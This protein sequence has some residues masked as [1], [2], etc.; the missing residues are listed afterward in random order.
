M[1][2]SQ[3]LKKVAVIERSYGRYLMKFMTKNVS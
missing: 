2:R 3:G 1:N